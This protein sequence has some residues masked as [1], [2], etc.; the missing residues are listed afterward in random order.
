MP[1]QPKNRVATYRFTP[2]EKALMD[3]LAERL[4]PPGMRRIPRVDVIRIALDRLA[5]A[6][7]RRQ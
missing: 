1:N 5:E 7:L 3:R 4:T 6:E 2:E